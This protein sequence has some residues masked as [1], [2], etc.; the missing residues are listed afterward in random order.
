MHAAATTRL[1]QAA[2]NYSM[3]A[4]TVANDDVGADDDVGAN[5]AVLANRCGG[6]LPTK[7][8]VRC[9]QLTKSVPKR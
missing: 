2:C 4:R 5:L 3:P 1:E 6:V 9:V 7:M 8:A